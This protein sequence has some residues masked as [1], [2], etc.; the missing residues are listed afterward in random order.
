MYTHTHESA[1][2]FDIWSIEL[3]FLKLVSL[4]L[5]LVNLVENRQ[6]HPNDITNAST[7]ERE[8]TVVSVAKGETK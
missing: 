8:K 6:N 7:S 2:C 1:L 5:L 3:S 4:S